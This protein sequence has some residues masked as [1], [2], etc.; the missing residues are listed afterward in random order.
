MSV[1][2]RKQRRNGKA[3][4]SSSQSVPLDQNTLLPP[5]HNDPPAPP[6]WHLVE[7]SY[8]Y[9]VANDREPPV[10]DP[11]PQA[12][13]SD[14]CPTCGQRPAGFSARGSALLDQVLLA[15]DVLRDLKSG[16]E[17]AFLP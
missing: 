7:H 1:S 10:V 8:T 2:R 11:Q 12:E 16:L 5:P 17:E 6:G 14:P 15:Q 4:D 3:P 9:A 13:A